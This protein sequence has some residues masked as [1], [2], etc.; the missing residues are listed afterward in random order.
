MLL[1]CLCCVMEQKFLLPKRKILLFPHDGEVCGKLICYVYE[2]LCYGLG[3][4]GCKCIDTGKLAVIDEF[5]SN[6]E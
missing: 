5:S 4:F 3:M 6:G 1:S 2:R